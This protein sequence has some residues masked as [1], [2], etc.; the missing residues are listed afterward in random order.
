MESVNNGN[1]LGLR[2]NPHHMIAASIAFVL[3]VIFHIIFWSRFPGLAL[4]TNHVAEE[5]QYH[6]IHLEEVRSSPPPPRDDKSAPNDR[7]RPENPKKLADLLGAPAPMPELATDSIRFPSP[8]EIKS[9]LNTQA[10]AQSGPVSA[11]DRSRWEPRQEIL[12]VE[13]PIVKDDVALL[14]RQLIPAVPR[15]ANAPDVILPIDLPMGGTG[16]GPAPSRAATPQVGYMLTSPNGVEGGLGSGTGIGGSGTEPG[17]TASANKL[18]PGTTDIFNEKTSDADANKAVE[19]Y[20]DLSMLLFRAPEEGGAGYFEL[21]VRRHGTETLPVLPK[22]V[23]FIQDCSESITPGKLAECKEGL[24]RWLETLGP[25]DR[26]EIISFRENVSHCFGQWTA[27]SEAS[28]RDGL[29]FIAGMRSVGNTDVYSSLD[30]ARRMRENDSRPIVAVLVTD[31]VPT[32]GMIGSSDIIE[33][34]TRLNRGNVPVFTLGA[35]KRV[36]HFLIDLLSYRNRGESTFVPDPS[37]IPAAM[38]HEAAELA[39]PVLYDLT[40]RMTGF[41][42]SQVYPQSLTHLFLDRPLVIYGRIA[43]GENKA[44]IQILGRAG[45]QNLDMI[46]PLDIAKALAGPPAI[47]E[48]WAWQKIYSLIGTYIQ[49]PTPDLLRTIRE[50]AHR[51][52]LAVPYGYGDGVPAE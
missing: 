15:V 9:P 44:A 40:Y 12:K 32:A 49:S 42:S 24:R 45:G 18:F 36:N 3:S 1:V 50:H 21:Q 4:L 11:P 6:A 43:P 26:F 16:K 47:R 10:P 28:R 31:G 39:R 51:Y 27:V 7:L 34:F 41:D 35:G 33:G 14:P 22:D 30:A 48:R 20:L 5:K 19:K 46:F 2:T 38:Q 52:G 23:L 29:A 8:P 25:Q 17:G 13:Q 37:G